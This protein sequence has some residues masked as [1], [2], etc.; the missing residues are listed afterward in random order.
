MCDVNKLERIEGKNIALRLVQTTDAGYVVGLRTDPAY[1]QYLSEVD[2][3][4]GGQQRWIRAYKLR[5][6]T[7][8]ELYYIIERLDGVPCGTIRLYN[9]QPHSFEWGSWILDSG[10]P[11]KAALESALLSF[12]LGFTILGRDEAQ[13][14]VL[15]ENAHAIA[16]YR[17]LGMR[18]ISQDTQKLYFRYDKDRF[19]SDWTEYLGHIKEGTRR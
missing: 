1:N 18:Q 17:R 3:D 4:I 13:V 16:F 11:P 5:E 19:L 8:R 12:E 6:A 14:E 2:G 15:K 10:K 7:C 9:V